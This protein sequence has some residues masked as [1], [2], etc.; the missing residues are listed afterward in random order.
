MFRCPESFHR[1]AVKETTDT[2]AWTAPNSNVEFVPLDGMLGVA[3][4]PVVKMS[5]SCWM[6]WS[7]LSMVLSMKR[8]R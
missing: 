1:I 6:R 8:S 5:T 2:T 4:T 7:G 3:P